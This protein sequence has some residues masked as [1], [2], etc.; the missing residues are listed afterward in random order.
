MI[1]ILKQIKII[2]LVGGVGQP[3]E[4]S[5]IIEGTL[6][7][8]MCMIKKYGNIHNTTKLIDSV[9]CQNGLLDDES[10]YTFQGNH[11]MC[12]ADIRTKKIKYG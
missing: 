7:G 1:G 5:S 6:F 8:G 3:L 10:I 11:C 4:V 9:I 2:W 12:N